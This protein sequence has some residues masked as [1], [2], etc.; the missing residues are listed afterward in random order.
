MR[1]SRI[2][3]DNNY[4]YKWDTLKNQIQYRLKNKQNTHIKARKLIHF[5]KFSSKK[6]LSFSNES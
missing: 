4:H 2:I 3:T 1:D 5:V 6:I